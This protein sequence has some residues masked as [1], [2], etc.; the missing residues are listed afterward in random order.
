MPQ[1]PGYFEMPGKGRRYSDGKGGIFFNHLGPSLNQIGNLDPRKFVQ[2]YMDENPLVTDPVTG[3]SKPAPKPQFSGGVRVQENSGAG[4][5]DAQRAELAKQNQERIARIKVESDA[6]V[7]AGRSDKDSVFYQAP[8]GGGG[9]GGGGRDTSAPVDPNGAGGKGTS[10]S[11]AGFMEGIGT[12]NKINVRDAF[13]SE[14]L[15]GTASYG[16]SFALNSGENQQTFGDSMAATQ[17]VDG[18]VVP[19]VTLNAQESGKVSNYFENQRQLTPGAEVSEQDSQNFGENQAKVGVIPQT[20]GE[21]SGSNSRENARLRARA[22]FLDPSRNSMQGLR[23][24]EGE[25]GMISQGGKKFARDS[26]AESG[27]REISQDAYSARM[28]GESMSSAISKSKARLAT[29]ASE[30]PQ[31]VQNPAAIG[32]D[33]NTEIIDN[34]KAL[35]GV[36]GRLTVPTNEIPKDLSGAAGQE[37]LR[38]LDAGMLTR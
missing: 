23:A 1:G 16:S 28:A 25:M 15:P 18:R 20:Q 26:G 19:K 34:T 6:T 21:K 33:G 35:K 31:D 22:A 9:G 36:Q 13:A 8:S 5:T 12:P 29:S 17:A 27:L 7:A 14:N 11:Y 38:K 37:Y 4:V 30:A 32:E 2:R 10:M 3:K 24:A